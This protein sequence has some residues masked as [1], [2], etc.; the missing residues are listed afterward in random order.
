MDPQSANILTQNAAAKSGAVLPI[1]HVNGF[2][3]SERTIYG[4]TDDKEMAAC[5]P[6]MGTSPELLTI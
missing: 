4:C 5:L 2:K 1:V 6:V 3:N